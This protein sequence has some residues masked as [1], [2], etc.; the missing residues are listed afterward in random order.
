VALRKSATFFRRN[1]AAAISLGFL[2][3][4]VL[5][6][7][8]LAPVLATHDPRKL[9]MPDRLEGPSPRHFFGTDQVGRDLYSRSVYGG[10]FSL[11]VG[12][13]VALL[14][15]GAA[16]IVGLISGW[17]PLADK[18]IM[19]VVDGMLAIPTL[20]LAI[21]VMVIFGP[22]VINVIGVLALGAVPSGSR[23]AR[24]A[25]LSQKNQ[26][27]VEA[28]RALG[29]PTSRIM[30]HHVVPNMIAPMAVVATVNVAGA[31]LAE[32]SLAFLGAGID[33]GFP[34]WGNMMGE[35]RAY[36]SRHSWMMFWPGMAIT[37]VV[38]AFAVGGDV[39]RDV[40][41]PRLRGSEQA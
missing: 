30:S 12:F 25:V 21:A 40:M 3:V 2:L 41:D 15:A 18:V 35:A 20:L 9:A 37:L 22:T 11:L 14:A 6:T 13:S 29:A 38:L 23:V 16:I 33:P 8:V 31:I 4:L 32:A 36:M 10:R 39:L 34:T 7:T 28:A 26:A 5:V 19:R 27:F 24:A 17:F 1:P